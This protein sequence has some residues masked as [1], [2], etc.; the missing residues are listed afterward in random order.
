MALSDGDLDRVLRLVKSIELGKIDNTKRS[1]EE[2]DHISGMDVFGQSEYGSQ[3]IKDKNTLASIIGAQKSNTQA[4]IENTESWVADQKRLN[5]EARNNAAA[6]IRAEY[7][8]SQGYR[9]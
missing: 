1:L 4:L 2:C 5:A 8:N 6:A 3:V 9:L 7:A